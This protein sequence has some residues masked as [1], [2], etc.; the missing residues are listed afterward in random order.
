M[1]SL[2]T[3]DWNE[4]MNMLQSMCVFKCKMFPDR[5]FRKLKA[6]LCVQVDQQIERVI[7]LE[8]FAPVVQWSMIW[9][10]MILSLMLGLATMQANITAAFLHASLDKGKE[11][12]VE[13]PQGFRQSGKVYKLK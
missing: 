2:D 1:K 6:K 10:M 8:T 3:I 13:I 12:Y 5:S 4:D 7:F 9:L 11:I